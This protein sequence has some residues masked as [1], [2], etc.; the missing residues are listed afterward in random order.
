MTTY[1]HSFI[2]YLIFCFVFALLFSSSPFSIFRVSPLGLVFGKYSGKP[3]LILD[4]SWPHNDKNIASINDLID[5][6]ECSMVYSTIDQAINTI[7]HT[8]RDTFLCKCDIASAFKLLPIHPS[9]VPYYGCCWNDQFY[10][11]VRLPFG[12]RSSPRIFDCLSQALEWILIHNYKVH[13]CQH[14]LDDFLTIDSSEMADLRTKAIIT[15]IFKQLNIPLSSSKTIGPVTCL[16][17]LG[18]ILDTSTFETRIPIDKIHRMYDLLRQLSAKKR[19]T[20]RE[21][22]QLIGHFNFATRV[23]VPGRSFLSY[24]FHLSCTVNDLHLHVR[25]GKEA[26][27]DLSMW[28]EFLMNWN[29][30]SLFL[31]SC[32]INNSDLSLYTDAAGSHGYGGIFGSQ[33]FVGSWD[34][35]FLQLAGHTRN[36]TLLELVPIVISA[37]L[38]GIQWARRRIVFYCDNQALVFILNKRRSADPIIMLFIRRLTLLSLKYN[39][40]LMALHIAGTT[41]EIADAISRQQWHRFRRLAPWADIHPCNVPNL[42]ELIYPNF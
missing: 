23:I 28:E 2:H 1:I 14:L 17:Y 7:L 16:E 27:I 19:C 38:W 41:N 26:R 20:K 34:D 9:L 5:K 29:G 10:F 25:L 35:E 40:H 18:V 36:S 6:D 22:L 24:L 3:R 21:L 33:W 37:Y 30:H 4:L 32:S 8:G 42:S 12:G 11:F 15:M 39:F 31:E 13:Y